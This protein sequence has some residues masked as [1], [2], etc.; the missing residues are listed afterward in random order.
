VLDVGCGTGILSMFSAQAGAKH[1]YAVDCSSIIEQA[2]KIVEINGFAD[3][4]TLIKGKVRRCRAWYAHEMFMEQ[5]LTQ[6]FVC[7]I[8][9]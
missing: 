1:V 7:A 5:F 3:K 2:K 9:L 6:M 8:R 4:I